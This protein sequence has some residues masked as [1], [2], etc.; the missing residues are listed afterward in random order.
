MNKFCDTHCDFVTAQIEITEAGRAEI[1]G[2]VCVHCHSK[3]PN[4][5]KGLNFSAVLVGNYKNR[6]LYGLIRILYKLQSF[7]H[8]T[9]VSEKCKRT[10]HSRLSYRISADRKVSNNKLS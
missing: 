10:F 3:Y 7:T 5:Y 9:L 6:F 1:R 2:I 4:G 8:V